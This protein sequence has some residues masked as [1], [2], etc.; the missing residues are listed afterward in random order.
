C[1]KCHGPDEKAR[2]SRVRLDVR[3]EA[4]KPAP[5]GAVPIVPGNPDESEVVA[6][7]FA[8]DDSERMPPPAAK[9]PLSEQDKQI[10]KQWIADAASGWPGAPRA[11][12]RLAPKFDRRVHHRPSR[13]RRLEPRGAGR[14]TELDP[15]AVSRP[16]WLAPD[17]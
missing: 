10:L 12:H 11:A 5:S 1:F 6:R 16:G 3:D 7:I 14:S 4:V 8:E 15:P 17:A 9:L 2:K 13:G